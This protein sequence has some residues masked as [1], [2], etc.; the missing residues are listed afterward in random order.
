MD[1]PHRNSFNAGFQEDGYASFLN[2]INRDAGIEVPFRIAET[3]VFLDRGFLEKL[4][5]AG[6]KI[7]NGLLS[8]AH[9]SQSINAVPPDSQVPGAIGK[10]TMLALDFA[11]CDDV[12]GGY[13]PMLIELQGFPSLFHYQHFLAKAFKSHY[14]E[15]GLLKHVFMD[16]QSY[17]ERLRKL[18]LGSCQPEHTILLE[19]DPKSQNTYIDFL[20]AQRQLGIDVVCISELERVNG[21]L[22][23]NKNGKRIPVHRIYNRV[24]FDELHRRP[25]WIRNYQLTD[26]VDVE[27]VCH[28]DWYFRISK[29]S[30]P[31]LHTP[32]VPESYFVN[33][34]RVSALDLA[35]FVLKPLYSFSG[36]GVELDVDATI[37]QKIQ[38]PAMHILQR[39]VDYAAAVRTPDGGS[40]VEVRLMYTWLE[41]ELMP[42]P[43]ITLARLSQGKMVGVKYNRDKT[44]VGSS[45]C[46]WD[47]TAFE[48]AGSD[49]MV[50]SDT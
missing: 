50:P 1:A 13:K 8:D 12:A 41:D 14:P 18:I 28:P 10:P 36:T 4:L 48:A 42:V 32:A 19:L 44:W 35:Q 5:N 40:K 24:I 20:L 15:L 9:L 11:V 2:R 26:A 47:A 30:L 46:L 49:P 34:P 21:K 43:T 25:E 16:E 27:W 7:L 38:Q 6:E 37:L 31:Y 29:H 23:R 39:K 45:V 17:E 3:P 22:V 33:D